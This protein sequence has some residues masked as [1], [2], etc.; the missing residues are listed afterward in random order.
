MT[1][2][3]SVLLLFFVLGILAYALSSNAKITAIAYVIF[4]GAWLALC[5]AWAGKVWH[6]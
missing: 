5:F 1:L 3:I 6:L 2:T 4:G